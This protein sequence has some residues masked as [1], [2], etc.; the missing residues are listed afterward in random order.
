MRCA[1]LLILLCTLGT[2]ATAAPAQVVER[3]AV[4]AGASEGGPGRTK[5]RY[6]L[7]DARTV[8]RV[9]DELGGVPLSQQIRLEE[10]NKRALLDA[11]SGLGHRIVSTSGARIELFVYYSGHS[12]EEGLLLKDERLPYEELRRALEASPADVRIA[13]LDSCASGAMTRKKGGVKRPPFLVDASNQ[14]RG[15]AVLTS[16]SD[17]EAAQESDRI[18]ASFFTHYLVSGLRGAADI[19]GDGRVTLNEAYQFAFHETLARTERTQAGAQHPAYDIQLVGMGDLVMTDLRSTSAALI[20]E[21]AIDGRVYLRDRRGAL[22]AELDKPAGREV[23]LGLAPGAYQV[24]LEQNGTVM[25]GTVELRDGHKARLTPSGL[26]AVQVEQTV[27]RGGDYEH[28]PFNIALIPA[29]SFGKTNKKK[30]N[31]VL[32]LAWS[33]YA[34]LQG[35]E[36]GMGLSMVEDAAY[37]AQI[38]MVGNMVFGPTRGAQLSMGFNHSQ[39][40]V[41]GSQTSM[42]LNYAGGLSGAQIALGVNISR[43]EAY[44]L[45]ATTGVNVAADM[46]GVQLSSGLNYAADLRGAQISMLNIAGSVTGIQAGL[47]NI[48]TGTVA[49]TQVGLLNY[50]THMLGAPL[51]LL[52][53]VARNGTLKPTVWMSDT[54]LANVGIK[55]GSKQVYTLLAVGAWSSAERAGFAVGAG[56]GGHV[57]VLEDFFV[58]FDAT[59]YRMEER[60]KIT[61]DSSWMMQVRLTPG[62][63][64]TDNIAVVAGPVLNLDFASRDKET[65]GYRPTYAKTIGGRLGPSAIW[66]GFSVG[67]Q[68]F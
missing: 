5:L 16:S 33:K 56:L 28:I 24:T 66:P 4:L 60:I 23:E 20:I 40:S 53:I 27:S 9:L 68:F 44:G 32:N 62:W 12:D 3:Y 51:G 42:A 47:I 59:L 34:L 67:L 6:A 26:E 41:V 10:P 39:G 31:F 30:Q 19:G 13:I 22:V 45:Q 15:Y 35:L 18:E 61:S 38:T 17:T 14:V 8:S 65:P 46:W 1:G 36:L 49:G 63:Q 52:N 7:K 29:L 55:L 25:G 43:A 58:D 50:A 21:E 54:A 57:H 2:Q 64:W 37:G 48:A 11:I